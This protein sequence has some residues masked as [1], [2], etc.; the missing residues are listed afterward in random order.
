MN[1]KHEIRIKAVQKQRRLVERKWF[2]EVG[3][4]LQDDNMQIYIL[5]QKCSSDLAPCALTLPSKPMKR[6]SVIPSHTRGA[7]KMG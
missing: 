1:I 6:M 2:Q 4:G 3:D 5:V 7:E